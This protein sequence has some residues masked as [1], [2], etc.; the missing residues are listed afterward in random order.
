[1]ALTCR[2]AGWGR[3]DDHSRLSVARG[4]RLCLRLSPLPDSTV[5]TRDARRRHR[6]VSS[7]SVIVSSSH[8]TRVSAPTRADAHARM[9]EDETTLRDQS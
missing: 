2:R 4:D 6:Q 9:R 5:Q 7:R 8:L 3:R 1:M